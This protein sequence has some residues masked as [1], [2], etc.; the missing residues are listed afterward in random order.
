MPPREAS[1][2]SSKISRGSR[3]GK[4]WPRPRR[5]ARSQMIAESRARVAGRIHR[6]LDVDDAGLHAGSDAF[7]FFLQAAGQHHI[8]MRGG[9]GEEEVDHAEK[10]EL[11]QGLA[12]EIRV[13]QRDQRIEADRKQRL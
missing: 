13:G 6:L 4:Y 8:G 12:R 3:K 10:F 2:S 5:C 1:R 11:L 9:L 7:L